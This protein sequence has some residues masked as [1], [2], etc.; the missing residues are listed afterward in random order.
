MLRKRTMIAGVAGVSALALMAAGVTAQELKPRFTSATIAAAGTGS[1]APTGAPDTGLFRRSNV[2]LAGLVQ[3]AH[4]ISGLQLI[5]GPE[6]IREERFDVTASA[7]RRMT[8][9]EM[10]QLVQ[11]LL[12]D[13]FALKLGTEVR[14]MSH[15]VLRA[16]SSDALG[17]QLQ[18]C[19]PSI[20]P[21]A[22]A[23]MRLPPGAVP[24]TATC[25]SIA[26][27]AT[28]AST[29]VAAPVLDRS[30]LEGLW[31]YRITVQQPGPG[32]PAGPMVASAFREHLGL[33]LQQTKGPLP[34]L[35]VQSVARPKAK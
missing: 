4:K 25:L 15:Y 33:D 22:P 10:R 29:A 12:E 7:G 30:S 5:G 17:P 18:R 23:P 20:P 19:D 35:V 24:M 14:N 16:S 34:V 26:D 28:R 31:S 9:D 6:W 21:S 13:E 27:I 11:S 3:F 8:N 32:E 2:T 1:S